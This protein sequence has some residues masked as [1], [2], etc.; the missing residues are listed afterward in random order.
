MKPK[1][2]RTEAFIELL[3]E[4]FGTSTT[5]VADRLLDA[6][7][8]SFDHFHEGVLVRADEIEDELG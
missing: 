7:W 3:A 2:A 6:G 1:V 8:E 4:L 5:E